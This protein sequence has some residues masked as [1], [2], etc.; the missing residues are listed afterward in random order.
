MA[1]CPVLIQRIVRWPQ[2]SNRSSF[3]CLVLLWPLY[4]DIAPRKLVTSFGILQWN[5]GLNF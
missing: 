4:R 3:N 1:C 2:S 5:Y